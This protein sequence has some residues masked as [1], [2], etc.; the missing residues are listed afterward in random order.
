MA[1]RPG[2]AAV[3]EV[4]ADGDDRAR[5]GM[6]GM[7][8]ADPTGIVALAAVTMCLSLAGLVFRTGLR[9]SLARRLALLLI[10]EALALGTSGSIDVL[11]AGIDD[12][13]VRYPMLPFAEVMLHAFADCAMLVLYPPF[14]A[15]A[16]NTRLTQPFAQRRAVVGIALAAAVLYVAVVRPFVIAFMHAA[17]P[18][19]VPAALPAAILYLALVALFVFAFV[20]SLDA[21][22]V[23]TGIAR[24]RARIFA[25]AFG[26]RDACW[27]L[28]YGAMVWFLS[29]GAY[30]EVFEEIPP[31]FFVY[32]LGTFVA[33]P[34][35]A[36]GILRAQLFDIDLRI[37]WTIK[38]STL[39]AAVVAIVYAVS[40]GASRLLSSELG[41]VAGLLAAAVVVFFL[42]P[43]QRFAE[44]VA[45]A[46][47]PNTHNTPEYA[48]FRKLQ[49]FE[50][51]VAEALPGGMSEKERSILRRLQQSLGISAGDAAA[52]EETLMRNRVPT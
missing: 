37:R 15:A 6:T 4:V 45:S 28:V 34:L 21:W 44:R 10:V 33:V 12:F 41:N 1:D 2:A 43:L 17:K 3:V 8:R 39:A 19:Y 36:Y 35:I 13:Y 16:L 50:A 7:L 9:G 51:A 40:E 52:I 46:A 14:L 11:F 29:T 30:A 48:A 38:Q 25:F 49:V 32:A 20:A 42:A 27:G 47:M 18:D 5:D 24:K 26:F 31:W 23:S 22:R